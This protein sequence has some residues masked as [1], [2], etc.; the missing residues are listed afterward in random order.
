MGFSTKD[1]MIGGRE[2]GR[3][4]ADHGIQQCT[5]EVTRCRCGVALTCTRCGTL[6]PSIG[7]FCR[8]CHDARCGHG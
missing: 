5:G 4:R 6:R 8:L 3:K 7:G 1:V 2:L